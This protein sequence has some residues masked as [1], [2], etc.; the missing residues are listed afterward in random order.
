M[1][2]ISLVEFLMMVITSLLLGWVAYDDFRHRTIRV[3]LL[4]IIFI[5]L[6]AHRLIDELPIFLVISFFLNIAYIALVALLMI[7]YLFLRYKIQWLDISSFIGLGDLLFVVSVSVWFDIEMFI[8]FTTG[9]LMV[10]LLG[11]FIQKDSRNTVPVAGYQSLC[12]MVF[13][14]FTTMRAW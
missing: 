13:Y 3:I 4:P 14:I 1:S 12:F 11:S 2:K 5:L 8:L 7:G 10:A 6:A 9:S